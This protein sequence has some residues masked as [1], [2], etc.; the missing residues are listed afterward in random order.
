MS[1]TPRTG[2]PPV[3]PHFE[4]DGGIWPVHCVGGTW[5]AELHPDLRVAG[6][7]VRKGR[8]GEDGYSGFSLRDPRTGETEPTELDDLLRATGVRHVVIVGLATDY[9]VLASG[10]DARARDYATTVLAAGSGPSNSPRA[11]VSAR[12]SSCGE[13]VPS[14][15]S[16]QTDALEGSWLRV[17]RRP[18][19][20]RGPMPSPDPAAAAATR[21]P[22]CRACLCH[23]RLT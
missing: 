6:P 19:P 8:N 11:T 3:T 23:R 18:M 4:K 17:A 9:C 13:R 22:C 12:S 7:V 5:G 20:P 21:A 2:I 15:T 1:S 10:L 14:W 16:R